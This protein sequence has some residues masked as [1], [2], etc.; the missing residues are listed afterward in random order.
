MEDALGGIIGLLFGVGGLVLGCLS[1]AAV[2]W[3][4]IDIIK[5]EPSDTNDKIIWIIVVL[6]AG[7]LMMLAAT[8][9]TLLLS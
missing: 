1:F 7:C 2:I 4:L 6:L 5:N 9:V 8:G 3:A